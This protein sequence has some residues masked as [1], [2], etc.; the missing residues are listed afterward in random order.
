MKK[1]IQEFVIDFVGSWSLSEPLKGS[2][3][4]WGEPLIGFCSALDPSFD[5][6]PLIASPSHVMP[7]DVLEDASL[8]M[9]YFLPYNEDLCDVE[10]ADEEGLE[11][12]DF[13]ENWCRLYR[14][15]NYLMESLH[16]ELEHIISEKGFSCAHYPSWHGSSDVDREHLVSKWSHSHIGEICGLGTIGLHGWLITEKGCAGRVGSIVTNIPMDPKEIKFL[17]R[18]V[19]H[20]CL[21]KREKQ[22]IT[23][24]FEKHGTSSLDMVV[25][26][27]KACTLCIGKCPVNALSQQGRDHLQCS[28]QLKA[29]TKER[30]A[31]VCGACAIGLPCSHK[32]PV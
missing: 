19:R 17:N 8:I 32:I 3:H 31:R 9:S 10:G 13:M 26:S 21:Y 29:N 4:V 30:G 23:D 7:T 15:T 25:N 28:S 11:E 12:E 14:E 20:N 5:S 16:E 18:N 1:V 24:K 6:L 22:S 2:S 27:M